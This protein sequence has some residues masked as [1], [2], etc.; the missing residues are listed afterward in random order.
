[1]PEYVWIRC[2]FSDFYLKFDGILTFIYFYLNCDYIW[3]KD[4]KY[5]NK[6]LLR[7][8]KSIY[9]TK[10]FYVRKRLLLKNDSFYNVN[11]KFTLI[12]LTINK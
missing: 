3:L 12:M 1:M 4:T 10:I 5:K 11:F 8:E 2:H 7:G 9:F 6:I